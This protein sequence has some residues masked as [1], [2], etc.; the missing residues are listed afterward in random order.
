MTSREIPDVA[1]GGT[2]QAAWGND[3]AQRTV[4]RYASTAAFPTAAGEGELA[5]SFADDAIFYNNGTGWVQVATGDFVPNAIYA[6]DSGTNALNI[7]TI[8]TTILAASPNQQWDTGRAVLI[9]FD[10]RASFTPTSYGRV[11]FNLKRVTASPATLY[12]KELAV[13]GA[14]PTP[15]FRLSTSITWLDLSYEPTSAY[16]ISAQGL[17][18]VGGLGYINVITRSLTAVQ[19]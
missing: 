10:V 9:N 16:Q 7:A 3:V 1:G 2:V 19:V 12:S 13:T 15:S 4:Q 6:R 14:A 18:V 5:Y 17:E 11:Q 8:E